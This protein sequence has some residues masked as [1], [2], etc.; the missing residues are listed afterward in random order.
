MP[1]KDTS[2]ADKYGG[3]TP[4]YPQQRYIDNNLAPET[5]LPNM[6]L[7]ALAAANQTA[8][9]NN[10]MSPKLASKML[11]TILTEGTMGINGWGYAD[12]P[13]YRSILIKAGLPPTIE[14]ISNLRKNAPTAFDREVINAKL[15]HAL[16]AVK[17]DVYGEDKALER[18]NGK[19]KSDSYN[20][21]ADAAHHAY[22]VDEVN[23][24]L[25]HPKNKQMA[26]FYADMQARYRN[27][28]TP[29][30]SSL[31]PALTWADENLPSMFAEPVNALINYATQTDN[32][33]RQGQNF[34]RNRTA[35]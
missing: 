27:G 1:A 23:R 21:P 7:E 25:S 3:V 32:A 9:R 10:L 11:P 31:P 5:G 34:I 26:D 24:L 35:F 17:A 13:K 19:G 8:L 4:Y 6:D 30:A 18:W 20:R 29:S 15:V 12:T 14:E 2:W 28:T 22:K 33:L 16:M